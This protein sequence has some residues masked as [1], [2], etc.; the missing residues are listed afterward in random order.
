PIANLRD[1]PAEWSLQ[2]RAQVR[3]KCRRR[4]PEQEEARFRT[5]ANRFHFLQL[6]SRAV[7]PPGT[8]FFVTETAPSKRPSTSTGTEKP[9]S[10]HNKAR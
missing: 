5:S 10:K 8:G 3:E 1:A 2:V 6:A 4:Q 9:K 7:H